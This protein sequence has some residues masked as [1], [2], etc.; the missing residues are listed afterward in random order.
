MYVRQG[1]GNAKTDFL[2]S[3]WLDVSLSGDSYLDRRIN[4][5]FVGRGHIRRQW[6]DRIF[7]QPY[8]GTGDA[9]NPLMSPIYADL[10]G[11]P[12]VFL[13]VG[14]DEVFLADSQCFSAAAKQANV[15]CTL[16]VWPQMW[17]AFAVFSNII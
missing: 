7:A 13:Q 5:A 16:E 15:V 12:L 14:S 6:I 10:T 3:V 9:K 4:D 2:H 17:H 11:L 8:I 1:I